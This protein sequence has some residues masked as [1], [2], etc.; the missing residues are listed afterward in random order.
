MGTLLA[1]VAVTSLVVMF[2]F[3]LIG[4]GTVVYLA[5][6]YLIAH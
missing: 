5:D 3:A 6:K 4:A 2:G 1:I